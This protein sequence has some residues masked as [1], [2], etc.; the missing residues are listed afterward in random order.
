M[1]GGVENSVNPYPR[2]FNTWSWGRVYPLYLLWCWEAPW[3]WHPLLL[4]G[5]CCPTGIKRRRRRRRRKRR[6][7]SKTELVVKDIFFTKKQIQ[8]KCKLYPLF[9]SLLTIQGTKIPGE[10][11]V[12]WG[13]FSVVVRKASPSSGCSALGGTVQAPLFGQMATSK[14]LGHPHG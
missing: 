13:I 8:G 2:D 1:G 4:M 11:Q 3:H 14:C 12:P 10:I 7:L 6:K 5:I 9:P